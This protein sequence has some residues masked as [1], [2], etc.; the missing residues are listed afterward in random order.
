MKKF[1]IFFLTIFLCACSSTTR[2]TNDELTKKLKLKGYY[3]PSNGQIEL[4]CNDELVA[5]QFFEP[6]M[7][8]KTVCFGKQLKANCGNDKNNITCDLNFNS[9]K[10]KLNIF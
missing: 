9:V 7:E 6:G 4:Y 10:L 2:I 5:R 3:N 1:I 8:F